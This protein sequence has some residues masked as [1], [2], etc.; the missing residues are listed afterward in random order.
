MCV[1]WCVVLPALGGY[2]LASL[3]LLKNPHILHK[4]KCVSFYCTHISHRGGKRANGL[5]EDSEKVDF[6]LASFSS[7]AREA[8]KIF[9][10][11]MCDLC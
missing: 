3:Y 10:V 9:L 2:T 8:I 7:V 11:K 4:R 1:F 5:E 6:R